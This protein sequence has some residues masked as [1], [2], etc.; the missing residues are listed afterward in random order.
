MMS[1]EISVIVPAFNEEAYLPATLESL[2]H[3][4]LQSFEVIVVANGCTDRTA[5][6]ARSFSAVVAELGN[7]NT[8][9]ARNKG[10]SM[11]QTER[12]AF[13]DADT[14]LSPN[15]LEEICKFLAEN[16]DR[17]V[18]TCRMEPEHKH[19]R[20]IALARVKNTLH[21]VGIPWGGSGLI[22]C[23]KALF[24]EVRFNER[25]R[26]REDGNFLRSATHLV[27]ARYYCLSTCYS[28]PSLRKFEAQGYVRYGARWL[29]DWARA[30][31]DRV[32]SGGR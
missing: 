7:S 3:Q 13:L 19:A 21:C 32:V 22:F 6:V 2:Q 16:D 24:E 4:T 28:V 10:A 30:E 5:D 29:R 17:L 25:M 9:A 27:G 26:F 12:F 31:K 11:A 15:A 23:H 8:S 1:P 20:A 18:G 14:P